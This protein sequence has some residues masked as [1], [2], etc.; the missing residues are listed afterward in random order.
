MPYGSLKALSLVGPP[1][2]PLACTCVHTWVTL[3]ARSVCVWIKRLLKFDGK[4]TKLNLSYNLP[5][6]LGF[7]HIRGF[8]PLRSQSNIAAERPPKPLLDLVWLHSLTF[9][10]RLDFPLSL[11]FTFTRCVLFSSRFG[12]LWL[13]L[14]QGLV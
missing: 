9:L 4:P 7:R 10:R 13:R 6:K 3:C 5:Q 8:R 1:R 12:L 11:T 2:L 14:V